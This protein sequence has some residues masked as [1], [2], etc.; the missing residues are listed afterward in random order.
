[1][2][3]L[4]TIALVVGSAKLYYLQLLSELLVDLKK[5]CQGDICKLQA[6]KQYIRALEFDIKDEI[7]DD[8]TQSNYVALLKLIDG[9][10][11]DYII[12]YSVVNPYD[13]IGE[14]VN[15]VSWG[16]ISGDILNQ[17]DLVEYINSIINEESVP[18]PSNISF[19]II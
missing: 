15:G 6:I 4:E 2:V 12:D 18:T 17:Q 11:A 9:Y 14:S 10:D 19:I 13:T 7:N 8:T 5:G 3:P 16:N 1:M